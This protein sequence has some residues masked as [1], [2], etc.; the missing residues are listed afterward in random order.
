VRDAV[1]A[2][3]AAR[4]MPLAALSLLPL[5]VGAQRLYF[6]SDGRAGAQSAYLNPPFALIRRAV[7]IFTW[8]L[9]AAAVLRRPRLHA[10]QY[11]LAGIALL[12]SMSFAA[13]DGVAAL[14]PHWHSSALGLRWC[15]D[16]VFASAAAATLW[17]SRATG[18]DAARR[19]D[20]AN[21]LLAL[22]LGWLYLSFVDYITAWSGNLPDEA[23]WYLPR[24]HGAW[25][26]LGLALVATHVVTGAALLFRRLKIRAPVLA[27]IAGWLLLAQWADAVWLV[28]PGR[29]PEP[30]WGAAALACTLVMLIAAG[31]AWLSLR[32]TSRGALE[33]G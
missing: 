10:W 17:N 14:W 15:L 25:A 33:H 16:G 6:W 7:Y 24:T 18:S 28:F 11:A 31:L 5:V 27:T 13:F 26:W 21:L 20:L 4:C 9:I 19:F 8:L 22:N 30:I 23:A 32:P 12:L 2:S 3:L 29:A 1:P